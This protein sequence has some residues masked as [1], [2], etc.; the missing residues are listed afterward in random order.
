M[1]GKI[2]RFRRQNRQKEKFSKTETQFDSSFLITKYRVFSIFLFATLIP[3]FSCNGS[4]V[5]RADKDG[6]SAYISYKKSDDTDIPSLKG[7]LKKFLTKKNRQQDNRKSDNFF[8]CL[9]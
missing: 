3:T 9:A 8:F 2:H 1:K 6:K 4:W 7:L 5:F